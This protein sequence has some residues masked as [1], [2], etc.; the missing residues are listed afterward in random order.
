ME[1]KTALIS[2][3]C[4]T[5]V[6]FFFLFFFFFFGLFFFSFFFFCR[7]LRFE[8]VLP[9][10]KDCLLQHV[11][12]ANYQAANHGRSL[13]QNTEAP[14]PVEHGLEIKEDH[15]VMRLTTLPR[16]PEDL[17]LRVTCNVQSV[18][19]SQSDVLVRQLDCCAQICA[20]V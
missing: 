4:G 8:D 14:T 12:R 2:T 5:T 9:P 7:D 17:L 6:L 1:R 18:R 19:A 3:K 16:T 20:S 11:N 13:L 10:T 15:I